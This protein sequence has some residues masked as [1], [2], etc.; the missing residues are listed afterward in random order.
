VQIQPAQRRSGVLGSVSLMH[1]FRLGSPP[2]LPR[3]PR[4]NL[5]V[6]FLAPHRQTLHSDSISAVSVGRQHD[7]AFPPESSDHHVGADRERHG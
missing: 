5:Q 3:W 7:P 4:G 2:P 1:H 6:P